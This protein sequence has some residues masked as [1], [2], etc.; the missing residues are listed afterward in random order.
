MSEI[1]AYIALGSNLGDRAQHLDQALQFLAQSPGVAVVKVSAYHETAPVGG[2]AGQGPYLNAAA[3][4]HTTLAAD[5]VSRLLLDIENKLGRVRRE[6]HGPRTVDLDL[7]LFGQEKITSTNPDLIV[8]IHACMSGYSCWSRWPRSRPWRCTRSWAARSTICCGGCV[9]PGIGSCSACGPWSPARPAA[10]AGPL[11]WSFA[12]GGADVI[13]HGRRSPQRAHDLFAQVLHEGVRSQVIMADLRL[14][15]ECAE[16]AEAGWNCFDGVDI[17]VNNAGTDTLTGE[18][19]QWSFDKKLAELWA[20]DVRA[21]MQLSRL[22][23]QRMQ[24][25]GHGVI[26]NMGW[27]QAETG[28]AGDS[29]ELFAAIKGAVMAFSKSLALSLAPQGPRPVPGPRL[30]PHRLGRSSI[31]VVAGACH[32][33]NTAGP[34]G[35][36]RGRG[37][38]RALAGIASGGVHD[39]ADHPDQ[40]RSDLRESTAAGFRPSPS[41]A[42]RAHTGIMPAAATC[43]SSAPCSGCEVISR[44]PP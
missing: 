14:E 41:L 11:P 40:W 38:G 15:S 1:T 44:L 21:T 32:P 9:G 26:I 37:S 16:L 12:R 30:D 18:A 43:E 17:W 28:M 10:S 33:R 23:G 3:E 27:D 20:V 34:L 6:H 2:P 25:R 22:I 5:P 29:G 35:H 4:L 19:A 31:S 7:L 24:G 42:L 8:R 39:G 36:S 13:I